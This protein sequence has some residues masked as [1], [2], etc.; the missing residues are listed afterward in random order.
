MGLS[1]SHAD[2]FHDANQVDGDQIEIY[3]YLRREE[4]VQWRN[5]PWWEHADSKADLLQIHDNALRSTDQQDSALLYLDPKARLTLKDALAIVPKLMHNGWIS[6]LVALIDSV[7]TIVQSVGLALLSKII[8][9]ESAESVF[10]AVG[11]MNKI[12][13]LLYSDSSN[14]QYLA[15]EVIY[16]LCARN[17]TIVP[18]FCNLGLVRHLTSLTKSNA[19]E[20]MLALLKILRLTLHQPAVKAE[21]TPCAMLAVLME[22]IKSPNTAIAKVSVICIGLSLPNGQ[23]NGELGGNH[24]AWMH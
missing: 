15:L 12:I 3:E 19:P 24:S 18:K 22:L 20:L 11:G 8:H 10:V 7:D 14:V 1:Q 23:S 2:F 21:M 5:A 9:T 16:T 6:P 4:H 17:T 13:E